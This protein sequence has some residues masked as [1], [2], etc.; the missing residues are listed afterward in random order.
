MRTAYRSLSRLAL[1]TGLLFA[2]GLGLVRAEFDPAQPTTL[3][4]GSNRGIGL[5][6]V[7]Y[8]AAADWNVIATARTPTAATELQALAAR[9]PQIVIEQLDVTDEARIKALA[10][11]YRDTPIDLLINNAGV[12]GDVATQNLGALDAENFAEVMA[13][14]VLAPLK[15]AEAFTE[16]VAVSRQ[17]KIVSITSGAG[18]IS[19]VGNGAGIF[20][21][22]SKAALNMA[23]RKAAIALTD[24][25]I[26][27]A[28]IAPGAVDT[29]MLATARPG[30][31]GIEPERSVAGMAEVIAALEP[32]HDGRARSYDGSVLEW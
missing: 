10:A 1:G 31:R 8:Y 24:R 9:H 16:H 4:T 19:R 17:R 26:V 20:Y 30:Q 12:Y 13:I 2:A 21:S 22:T 11:Q 27:V 7:E 32:G 14:N 15:M 25:A 28:V 29:D 23:M 6:F 18:S 5:A 3:I